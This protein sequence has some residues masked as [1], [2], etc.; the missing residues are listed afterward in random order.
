ME[1][2]T[3]TTPLYVI[4]GGS[5]AL[6]QQLLRTVMA[7]FQG[8]KNPVR[9]FPKV[10]SKKQ[11]KAILKQAQSEN[12]LVIHSMVDPKLRAEIHRYAEK[13]ELQFVDAVG[14]LIELLT[15]A[16][17]QE[18]LGIPGLYRDLHKS[19]FDRIE[20]IN[21]TIDH[22]DGKNPRGW[23]QA[24]IMLVGVSRVGKTPLSLYLSMLGWKVANVPLISGIPIRPE[25]RAIDQ[26]RVVGLTMDPVELQK[27][28]EIRQKGMGLGAYGQNDYT[29]LERVYGDLREAERFMRVQGYPVIDTS[30]KP[31][32]ATAA[33]VTQ[34]V[35]KKLKRKAKRGEA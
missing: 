5:G 2:N 16:L 13:S 31:I 18:P 9:L 35:L 12:G 17:G 15:S 26:Y 1:L 14:P 6:G 22:D 33:E 24:E 23:D 11:L 25:F 8:V 32:E 7:Q 10:L 34:A 28:R 4:S 27:H 3:D 19:Y 21:F 30:N 29:D 20:A